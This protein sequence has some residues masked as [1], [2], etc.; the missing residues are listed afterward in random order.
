MWVPLV[1]A[2]CD[3]AEKWVGVPKWSPAVS[4]LP[5]VFPYKPP[6]QTLARAL[7]F[8][9]QSVTLW[10]LGKGAQVVHTFPPVAM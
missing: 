4:Q 5:S 1:S 3:A 10:R 6:L 9:Q 8:V 7:Q 2:K